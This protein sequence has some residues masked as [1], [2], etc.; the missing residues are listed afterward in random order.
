M[1]VIVAHFVVRLFLKTLETI[2]SIAYDFL[3]LQ[4]ALDDYQDGQ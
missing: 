4:C 3:M 2:R 1:P